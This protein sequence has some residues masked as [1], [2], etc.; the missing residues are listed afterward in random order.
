MFRE[1]MP[2]KI[3]D[4]L[5]SLAPLERAMLFMFAWVA[6][7]IEWWPL[8]VCVFWELTDVVHWWRGWGWQPHSDGGKARAILYP[9]DP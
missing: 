6:P 7:A 2:G 4:L 9:K 1:D 3:D 8:F 5:V